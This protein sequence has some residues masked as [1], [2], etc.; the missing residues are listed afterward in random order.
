MTEKGVCILDNE[1]SQFVKG[2]LLL[3]LAG[4]VSKVLSAGYRIPLQNLTGDFGFYIYQQIYP[5]L[6]IIL[7]LSLYGFPSA[8]SKIVAELKAS[9]K[10]ASLKSFYFPVFILMLA[11][12][13]CIFIMLHIYA[14]SIA[15]QIGDVGLTRAYQLVAFTF[16]FIP[17]TSLLRGVFQGNYQMKPTA[18][19]Q[20]GEQLVRVCI[21]IVMAYLVF[22]NQ[23]EVYQIGEIAVWASIMGALIAILILSVTWRKEKPYS[24]ETFS[25]PWKYY[26]QTIVLLGIVA[27]LN[28]MVLLIIQ[29]ADVFTL[30]PN[31]EKYGLS[32][33]EAMEAKGVFDR[34]QPL[35]QLGTVLGSSFALALIPALTK[36][37]LES[38]PKEV[39]TYIQS[40][41]L[42]SFYLATGA[43]IGLIFIFPAVNLLLF[44]DLKGTASLQV[45]SGAIFLSSIS[46]TGSSI[47]Q[48][49]GYFKRTAVFI[50]LAFLIKWLSNILLV[51]FWG[52]T[53]S[54]I[55]TICS[56]LFLCIVII[57]ELYRKLPNM[58]LFK[59]INGR[60]LLIASLGMVSFLLIV[61]YMLPYDM[62]SSRLLL[63]I[64]V[65]FL[66]FI[67]AMIYLLLLLKSRAFTTKELMMLP[68][69]SLWIKIHQGR[70][71]IAK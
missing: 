45:L 61:H 26:L 44:Q 32:S 66:A 55:A 46:I 67:G 49:L 31:L 29:F 24:K 3:T 59:E 51:P 47:L 5:F 65:M 68:Y 7:I 12:N 40:S 56:L 37:K 4:L 9:G 8:I 20:V 64:Y 57:L 41:L 17:F 36:Q 28:H 70:D 27:S 14:G 60:A 62:I 13:G 6:G 18:Y 10:T 52:I 58:K 33:I 23:I 39:S 34:G 22:I 50:L 48:G 21:I 63:L 53:G 1:R 2:A 19:S 38:D 71:R 54:A 35:I 25:V 11:M 42:F 15:K 43:V 30:V 69:A 16:L